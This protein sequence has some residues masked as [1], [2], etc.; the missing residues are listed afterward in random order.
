[1][2]TR[3]KKFLSYYRPYL[4]L[5]SADLF[6]AFVAAAVTLLLPLCTNYITRT[7]LAAGG[8][9]AIRQV[10]LVG[11][12]MVLLVVIFT[13]C[14]A[15]VDYQGH[16][17]GAL[18]ER[19]MRAELFAHL[20]RQPFHF[21]D[22]RK[23][24]Q[25]LAHF[26]SD[27]FA[28]SELYHHAPE[29]LFIAVVKAVGVFWILF[30]IDVQLSVALLL[31]LPVMLVYALYFNRKMHTALRA[32]LDRV[33]DINEQVEDTLAGI[34]VVQ[35]FTN[36]PIERGKFAAAN[37]R[38]VSSRRA[39]YRSEAYFHEGMLAFAELMLVA[40]IVFGGARILGGGLVIADLL[41]VIFCVG[42]LVDPIQRLVNVAR[43]FQE[44]ITGFERFIEVIEVAP[45]IAD[46]PGAL[47]LD[48][49]HWADRV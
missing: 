44:G 49:G 42:I 36:E 14:N 40:V 32:S 23:T 39:G 2:H 35:S 3:T 31:F 19:D 9:G 24:G 6:C 41:T 30:T 12:G 47:V 29:D 37:E 17:M 21:Y 48:R 22:Q 43:V 45:A 8:P 28:I 34:R 27:L 15:F 13:L 4:G 16:M 33:G 25:L 5:L 10:L 20:Q 18:M 1:M 11:L 46:A 7:V 26:T 38:F